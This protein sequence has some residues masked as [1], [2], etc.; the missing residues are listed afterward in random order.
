MQL[1]RVMVGGIVVDE[2]IGRRGE[3]A[4]EAAAAAAAAAADPA[5]ATTEKVIP[6]LERAQ[7]RR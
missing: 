6:R 3:A 1:K 7:R 2:S 5:A 4:V